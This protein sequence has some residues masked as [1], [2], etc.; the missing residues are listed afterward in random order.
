MV[1]VM[2]TT[3]RIIELEDLAL[4]VVPGLDPRHKSMEANEIREQVNVEI[5]LQRDTTLQRE[6]ILVQEAVNMFVPPVEGTDSG[7]GEAM[8]REN[9]EQMDGEVNDEPE[10]LV[11]QEAPFPRQENI[12]KTAGQRTRPVVPQFTLGP[13]GQSLCASILSIAWADRWE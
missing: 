12:R 8:D 7:V 4:E 1:R 10:A 11:Q 3:I 9:K 5:A 2:A 6:V 13:I